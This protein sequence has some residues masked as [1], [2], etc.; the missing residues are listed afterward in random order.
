[1]QPVNKPIARSLWLPLL[2]LAK[3]E[4]E[5]I[6]LHPNPYSDPQ[7]KMQIRLRVISTTNVDRYSE[8]PDL[9]KLK[10]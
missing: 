9:Q 4:S 1:M 10:I 6:I 3:S 5:L 7:K 2:G 8:Y